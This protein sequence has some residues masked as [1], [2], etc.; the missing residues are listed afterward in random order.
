MKNRD[1]FIKSDTLQ[2]PSSP[3]LPLVKKIKYDSRQSM[4]VGVARRN[5]FFW[6]FRF[7]CTRKQG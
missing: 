4:H 6:L 5:Y 7:S 1:L 2:A 3:G